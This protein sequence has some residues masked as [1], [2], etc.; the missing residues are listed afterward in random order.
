[1]KGRKKILVTGAGGLLGSYAL[2][3]MCFDYQVH[4]VVRSLPRLQIDNVVYHEIDF[5]S[6]WSLKELPEHLDTIIHLAQSPHYRRF[7]EMAIDVFNVNVDSTARLLDY[8]QKAGVEKFIYASSGGIYG[9]SNMGFNEDIPVT[10]I[11][12]LGFYQG[13]KLCSEILTDCYTSLMNVIVLRFFFVYGPGQKEH[14]LIPRLV[15]SV[16]NGIPINLQGENGIRINPTYIDDAIDKI[17]KALNLE[18]SQKLNVC[19]T[20]ILSLREIGE[21]IGDIVGRKAIF[22]T[23][24]S[25]QPKNL[26]GDI[27]KMIKLLGDSKWRFRDG[28]RKYI[29][30]L[31]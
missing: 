15:H 18:V 13:S 31:H 23:Q 8:G 19:G 26:I 6:R 14:M 21:I 3:N 20:E 25:E 9:Y 2:K 5:N 4:A 29:D 11:G 24:F 7:P 12:D 22:Q 30:S 28:V 10:S 16:M 27:N 17:R 1:M